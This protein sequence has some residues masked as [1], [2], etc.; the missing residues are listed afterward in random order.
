MKRLE[1]QPFRDRYGSAYRAVVVDQ[2]PSGGFRVV[3]TV[4][5]TDDE[6]GAEGV[7]VPPVKQS[8]PETLY[9]AIR[10]SILETTEARLRQMLPGIISRLCDNTHRYT[11]DCA[12]YETIPAVGFPGWSFPA[13]AAAPTKPAL[14]KATERWL[15]LSRLG[16]TKEHCLCPVCKP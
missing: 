12:G 5:K 2:D 11:L 3:C 4:W 7:G 6:E 10:C 1:L 8:A 13:H 15:C 9:S 14:F 16:Y